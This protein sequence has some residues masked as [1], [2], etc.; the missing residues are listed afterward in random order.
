MIE[1]INLLLRR[2]IV[3]FGRFQTES[4]STRPYKLNISLISSYPDLLK[5][6]AMALSKQLDDGTER[7]LGEDAITPIVSYL[8]ALTDIPLVYSRGCGEQTVF[9]LVGVYDINHPTTTIV[10]T[11]TN[12]TADFLNHSNRVGLKTKKLIALFGAGHNPEQ[13][14][15]DIAEVQHLWSM[16]QITA[17]A[18]QEGMIPTK[19]AE[20][21]RAYINAEEGTYN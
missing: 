20:L 7:L 11:V 10:G 2:G 12:Q 18:V 21:V 9:D 5:E 15:G 4:G 19:Q 6:T 3:Q 14:R 13:L 16:Q 1:H 8:S 17:A